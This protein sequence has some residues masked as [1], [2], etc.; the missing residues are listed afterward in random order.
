M[1]STDELSD[2]VAPRLRW[3]HQREPVLPQLLAHRRRR[4]RFRARRHEE[5]D[6]QCLQ[7][8]VV[9]DTWP[10]H[11]FFHHGVAS[12]RVDVW[13]VVNERCMT[14][15]CNRLLGTVTVDYSASLMHSSSVSSVG[16]SPGAPGPLC[17]AKVA[18]PSTD[19]EIGVKRMKKRIVMQSSV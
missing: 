14:Y 1:A 13:R 2:E 12:A 8:L 17:P 7:R 16:Q 6:F 18:A 10:R 9:R 15:R 19:N 4:R 3:R 5:K 11:L